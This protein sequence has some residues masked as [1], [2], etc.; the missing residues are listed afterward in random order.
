[1]SRPNYISNSDIDRWNQNIENDPQ[2]SKAMLN[3]SIIKEVMYAGLYLIDQLDKLNC[4]THQIIQIQ[5]TAGQISF[6]RD[7]WD[8]AQLLLQE[9]KDGK[10]IFE[11]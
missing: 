6:G 10:L 9:Y 3:C 5:F 8:I 4:P 11:D 2:I 1:M 7:P